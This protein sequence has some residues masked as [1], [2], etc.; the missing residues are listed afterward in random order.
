LC[1]QT[2]SISVANGC[3]PGKPCLEAVV[4]A[5]EGQGLCTPCMAA[6]RTAL[7]NQTDALCKMVSVVRYNVTNTGYNSRT[8]RILDLN[9]QSANEPTE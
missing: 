4:A 3:N 5:V 8:I 7:Q 1:L 9:L 6:R 2:I